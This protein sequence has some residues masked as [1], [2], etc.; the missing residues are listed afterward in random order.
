MNLWSWLRRTNTPMRKNSSPK[1][2]NC[3]PRIP[4]YEK[5]VSS[6]LRKQSKSHQIIAI[7]CHFAPLCSKRFQK[8][9]QSNYFDRE[10][11]FTKECLCDGEQ[12]LLK[13]IHEIK[14]ELKESEWSEN[15][16]P[17]VT[18]PSFLRT[19]SG[20]DEVSFKF[21]GKWIRHEVKESVPHS[22]C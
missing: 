19:D 10:E 3:S 18:Q 15:E 6:N 16:P 11:K 8:S 7:L 21:N 13:R 14:N 12:E 20:E 17:K 2:R 1:F 9:K 4:N 22:F 5:S